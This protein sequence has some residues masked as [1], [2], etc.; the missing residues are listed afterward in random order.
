MFKVVVETHQ[1]V[2]DEAE[3]FCTNSVLKRL[4]GRMSELYNE[5]GDP[6]YINACEEIIKKM[7]GKLHVHLQGSKVAS[8]G[9]YKSINLAVFLTRF[10][11]LTKTIKTGYCCVLMIHKF[12]EMLFEYLPYHC[13]VYYRPALLNGRRVVDV[14]RAVCGP[15]DV[16]EAE[17]DRVKRMISANNEGFMGEGWEGVWKAS[18]TDVSFTVIGFH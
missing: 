16:S 12:P 17:L 8:R 13:T 5:N 3:K 14:L 10:S 6:S 7:P 18:W 4:K 15:E 2:D 11:Y 9:R 1:A